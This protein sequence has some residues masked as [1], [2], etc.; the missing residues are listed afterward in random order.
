MQRCA[1]AFDFQGDAAVRCV[2]LSPSCG[3]WQHIIMLQM[4]P[5]SVCSGVRTQDSGV[6][7]GAR[8]CL[9]CPVVQSWIFC[10]GSQ[11]AGHVAFRVDGAMNQP[12]ALMH[13]IGPEPFNLHD[14]TLLWQS[15]DGACLHFN[16]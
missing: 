10:P 6:L 15:A 4:H 16:S 7:V 9:Q 2:Q 11:H 3:G 8:V 1:M 14:F 12:W 5:R 13:M